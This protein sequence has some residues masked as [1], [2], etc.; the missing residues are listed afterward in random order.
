[1]NR[2]DDSV[3]VLRNF[4]RH[5][6]LYSQNTDTYKSQQIRRKDAQHTGR[7]RE[8]RKEYKPGLYT[9]PMRNEKEQ[10]RLLLRKERPF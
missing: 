1:M 5:S 4:F 10:I 8:K 3:L 2:L 7:D 9:R 6:G